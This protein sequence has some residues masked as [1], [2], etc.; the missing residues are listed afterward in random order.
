MDICQVLGIAKATC[1]RDVKWVRNEWREEVQEQIE[2]H[3]GDLLAQYKAV[4]AAAWIDYH[5]SKEPRTITTEYLE[6]P[7]SKGKGNSHR[8][9]IETKTTRRAEEPRG[10][11]PRYL[12][13]IVSALDKIGKLL[14]VYDEEVTGP[15]G[16]QKMTLAEIMMKAHER[17]KQGEAEEL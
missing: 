3:I 11:D 4:I 17:R 7:A 8:G 10:G 5:G 13:A 6:L 15:P 16:D 2:Q 12:F 1:C 9:L 14:G